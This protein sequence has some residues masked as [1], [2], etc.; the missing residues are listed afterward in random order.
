MNHLEGW[1]AICSRITPEYIEFVKQE[2]KKYEKS[3]PT[4]IKYPTLS[5]QVERERETIRCY[6]RNKYKAL[7]RTFP[8]S[9]IHHQWIELTAK[10]DG[11]ALVN[12]E[13][14]R[15]NKIEIIRLLEGKI[16]N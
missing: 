5:Y 9:V 8:D 13:L 14:H 12:G 6:H 10:Y 2:E 4:Y 3:K 15:H 16:D 1:G 11:V 7:R